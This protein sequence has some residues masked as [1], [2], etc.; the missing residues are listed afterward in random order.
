M[1]I[2][3]PRKLKSGTWFLQLRLN[4]VSI[5]VSAATKA[6]CKLQAQLIKAEYRTGKR[7]VESN[8]MPDI[9]LSQAIDRYIKKRRNSLSPS[10]VRGYKTIQKNRF[11]DYMDKPISSIT[12]WQSVYDSE[13]DRLASKTLNNSFSL[14]KSVYEETTKKQMPEVD[15]V[16]TIVK[17]REFLDYEEIL[18]FCDVIKGKP[19]ECEALLALHSLRASELLD[20]TYDDID[21]NK[22]I[23]RIR[24][25]TVPD[26]HNKFVHKESNKTEEST[27]YIP[28]F[29]PRLK[30]VLKEKFDSGKQIRYYQRTNNLSLAI[31]DVCIENNLPPVSLHGLRHSFASLC[32]HL[33][34][35]EDVVMRLGGW[36]DYMTVHEIYTHI[37]KRDM[38]NHTNELMGFFAN[39]N[40]MSTDSKAH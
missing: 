36:S 29:I 27:R 22:W 7:A 5:P 12:D 3:E 15:K 37:S 35:P 19:W 40:K 32:V 26:E 6:E 4:G 33:G 8:K 9:T 31:K 10:T 24:G 38:R 11:Q 18:A 20:V 1:K 23:I 17:E 30:T 28:I 14:I 39:A 13:K 2:P 16:P 21:F 25:A 34:I